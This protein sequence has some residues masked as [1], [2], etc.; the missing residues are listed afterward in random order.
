V[1][2]NTP[3]LFFCLVGENPLAI[4]RVF[5]D[6]KIGTAAGM[7]TITALTAQK[8]NRDR[9]N[10]YLDGEFA[11][12]LALITAAWLKVG[13]ELTA[14]QIAELQRADAREV[15]QQLAINYISYRPRSV[16]EVTS[17]L[18]DKGYDDEVIA[19]IVEKLQKLELLN[20]KAFAAYW[21][22]QRESFRPKSRIALSQELQQ[23]GISRDL[24][25][26]SLAELD[27]FSLARRVAAKQSQRLAGLPRE[28]FRNKLG[29]F[30]QRRGYGYEVINEIVNE[31][32]Q[33]VGEE[34]ADS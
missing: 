30:L 15:G 1:A 33:S 11:F 24:I 32:W 26:S 10:V 17:H 8:R 7:A 22:E 23:K 3:R 20:D 14:E 6:S 9:V 34:P 29:R 27:E 2:V 25:E 21:V 4:G 19:L 12:G 31:M 28:T 16:A 13:Q 18:G 5:T